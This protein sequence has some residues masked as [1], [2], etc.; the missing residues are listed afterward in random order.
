MGN[1]ITDLKDPDSSWVNEPTEAAPAVDSLLSTLKGMTNPQKSASSQAEPTLEPEPKTAAPAPVATQEGEGI[2]NPAFSDKHATDLMQ[3]Q[4][5]A[6]APAAPTPTVGIPSN[7]SQTPAE[8]QLPEGYKDQLS[9]ITQAKA[10]IS[11]VLATRTANILARG[12]P[13]QVTQ[14]ALAYEQ[15]QAQQAL[16]VIEA[17]ANGLGQSAYQ[18]LSP[19]EKAIADQAVQQ[20]GLGYVDVVPMVQENSKASGMANAL[21]NNY[22]N[23]PAKL[24]QVQN[25]LFGAEVKDPNSGQVSRV[26]GLLTKN[27]FG[28]LQ[29][30]DGL[31]SLGKLYTQTMQPQDDGGAFGTKDDDKLQALQNQAKSLDERAQRAQDNAE[32]SGDPN[33]KLNAQIAAHQALAAHDIVGNY[34]QTKQ[35][36]TIPN[37]Q[38]VAQQLQK[39]ND[40]MAQQAKLSSYNKAV[41]D[42]QK[43][44]GATNPYDQAQVANKV[45]SA[46]AGTEGKPIIDANDP[47]HI[48]Q[49]AL[50]ASK[51][52]PV[53]Y[54]DE[55]GNINV[56]DPKVLLQTKS[57]T[58]SQQADTQEHIN[59][60]QT[61]L[62]VM[63]DQIKQ[64][65][66]DVVFKQ[67][68]TIDPDSL[69]RDESTGIPVGG[70]EGNPTYAFQKP[71]Q[72]PA[73]DKANKA[74]TALN[75]FQIQLKQ[76]RIAHGYLSGAIKPQAQKPKS[77]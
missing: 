36:G 37:A 25:Q 49:I 48:D 1:E 66:P 33:D 45:L 75:N 59:Q 31:V 20:H 67:D 50:S 46:Q 47:D 56:Q 57:Q 60:L 19:Q 52:G 63:R 26:G 51:P 38:D 16:S 32:Q 6:P 69:P 29:S 53:F 76:A 55:N 13:Q 17:H 68:G 77:W 12:L 10:E 27:K 30:N 14:Q 28:L 8:Q 15:S 42:A 61:Q 34:F 11:Q 43:K 35:I 72:D 70:F 9:N 41:T 24:Q 4:N 71:I 54:K 73:I 21:M 5:Q 58:P 74:A 40:V 2:P 23:D 18:G 62:P 7:V 65:Y 22:A 44:A 39:S 3:R 64:K